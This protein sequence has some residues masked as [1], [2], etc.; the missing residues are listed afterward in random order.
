[1]KSGNP[2]NEEKPPTHSSALR[3]SDEFASTNRQNEATDR[4]GILHNGNDAE[5]D[6][7]SFQY[8]PLPVAPFPGMNMNRA[9]QSYTGNIPELGSNLMTDFTQLNNLQNPQFR[10][11][12]LNSRSNIPNQHRPLLHI[13]CHEENLKGMCPS[14]THDN[15]VT[16]GNV[17]NSTTHFNSIQNPQYNRNSELIRGDAAGGYQIS[18]QGGKANGSN[19]HGPQITR[20]YVSSGG[21]A[22]MPY[23]N[24]NRGD[25]H[26]NNNVKV[27][28]V[29]FR[30]PEEVDGSFLTLGVG[31]DTEPRSRFDLNSE[32]ITNKSDEAVSSQL[33]IAHAQQTTRNSSN[34]G[35]NLAGGFSRFQNNVGGFSSLVHNA[36]GQNLSRDICGT[37]AG[38]SS[39]PFHSLQKP[40]VDM[41]Y[42]FPMSSNRNLGFVSG[43]DA[44][45]ANVGPYRGLLGNLTA[46]SG[47]SASIS[48]GLVDSRQPRLSGSAS[49]SFKLREAI[50]QPI[51][52]QLQKCST[53]SVQNLSPESLM[54]SPFVGIRGSS[55]RQDHSGQL[56]SAHDGRAT[57]AVGGGGLFPHTMRVQV[58]EG[59]AAQAARGVMFPKR[60]GIQDNDGIAGQA[61][62]GGLLPKGIGI[63]VSE[64]SATQ[65]AERGLCPKGIGLQTAGKVGRPQ[66]IIPDQFARNFCEPA[67][68]TGQLQDNAPVQFPVHFRG[69]PLATGRSQE[70]GPCHFSRDFL[71]PVSTTGQVRN[72]NDSGLS[73]GSSVLGGPF[74]K[75]GA[76]QPPP[77]VPRVQRR[78][79]SFQ[80]PV[81]PSKPSP[82]WTARAVS[83]PMPLPDVPI[84]TPAPDVPIPTPASAPTHLRWQGFDGLPQLTGQKCGL[85]MRDLSF[86]PPPGP[87]YQ[88][89]NKPPVAVLPCGHTFHD[90]CLQIITTEEHSKDPECIPCAF[91]RK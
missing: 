75:R 25:L 66:G 5:A 78:R 35:L 69:P 63:Q 90:H 39:S 68:S 55:T 70:G 33:N 2:N 67:F 50:T 81:R 64:A 60:L 80:P 74:S 62:G 42:D 46:S 38:P 13:P 40:Q 16:S 86:I 18:G 85:C 65:A 4:N 30:S 17:I 10:P 36:G 56:F 47:P 9:Y 21:S 1:M 82:N 12:S 22:P 28:A 59:H 84:P 44:R 72:A 8:L 7:L 88:P 49:E 73:Q 15:R 24:Q 76:I 77:A 48:A 79:I 83:I 54:V 61:A 26:I 23:H 11:N 3:E 34:L 91:Q 6:P 37:N 87:V 27:S 52:D 58:T 51:S 19:F 71:R 20:N 14:Q 31:C 43:T 29:P 41:Q 57:Q 89:S 45:Y 53:E 32:E